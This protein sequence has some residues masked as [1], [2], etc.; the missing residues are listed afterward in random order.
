MPHQLVDRSRAGTRV[1]PRI[2]AQACGLSRQWAQAVRLLEVMAKRSLEPPATAFRAALYTCEGTG[3]W[4]AALRMLETPWRCGLSPGTASRYATMRVLEETGRWEWSLRLMEEM[5]Q[6]AAASDA[7]ICST[8]IRAC[9]RSAHRV[10]ALELLRWSQS[11]GLMLDGVTQEMLEP[12]LEDA[13]A[14]RRI[15]LSGVGP[16]P[17]AE[18][19][20]ARL[21]SAGKDAPGPGPPRPPPEGGGGC[22]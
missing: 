20:R 22:P 11:R 17:R 1:R 15:P 19:P 7:V 16:G 5:S 12:L 10:P 21:S 9:A 13:S 3:G 4:E 14:R 18:A 8:A 6:P 2:R